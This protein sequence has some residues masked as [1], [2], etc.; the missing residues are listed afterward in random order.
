MD[1]KLSRMLSSSS[2]FSFVLLVIFAGI[3]AVF[4]KSYYVAIG[5]GIAVVAMFIFYMI[6]NKKRA[7]DIRKYVEDLAFQIDDATKLSIVNFPLPIAIMRIDGGEV[8]WGNNLFSDLSGKKEHLFEMH[9]K[10]IFPSFDT[11]W[12]MEGKQLCP[13][14]VELNGKSYNIYGSIVDSPTEKGRTL[15]A[16]LFLVD[17]TEY[18]DLRLKHEKSRPVVSIVVVD[19]YDELYKGLSESERSSLTASID[20]IITSWAQPTGGIIR[21][22][23]RD[24]YLFI[25][26]HQD[27]IDIAASKFSVLDEMKTSLTVRALPQHYL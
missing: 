2:I 4:L 21:R 16:T 7:K 22:L 11:K 20:S 24:R 6:R 18:S 5:E 15:L 9:I 3:T 17:I 26:E 8:I 25:F 12:L 1:K 10:D 14:E 27:Y 13:Y 19:S 23:D